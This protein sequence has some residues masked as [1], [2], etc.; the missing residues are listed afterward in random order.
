MQGVSLVSGGELADVGAGGLAV[1]LGL[2][3][4]P[5]VSIGAEVEDFGGGDGAVVGDVLI[6]ESVC[7]SVMFAI[8]W[9]GAGGALEVDIFGEDRAI[10]D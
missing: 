3:V 2:T 1:V 5:E 4:G 8:T 7:L 6:G 10:D 9:V